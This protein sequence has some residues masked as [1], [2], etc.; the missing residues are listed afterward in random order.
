MERLQLTDDDD[1]D[2]QDLWNSPSKGRSK[3][4][5]KRAGRGKGATL[6][7]P[8]PRNGETVL[9]H[10]E[11]TREAALRHE[12]QTVRNVNQAIEGILE[13]LTRAKGNMETVSRTVDSASTLLNTWTRILSQTEHNQRL[14][15]NPKW[16]GATQD[17]TDM[18]NEAIQK[19]QAA[20]RRELEMQQ[21][22]EAA[23]KKAEEEKKK[24]EAAAAGITR[25]S[26]GT[27]R[28]RVRAGHGRSSS[29]SFSGRGQALGRGTI[30]PRNVSSGITRGS[31]TAR[32]RGKT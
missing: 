22:R 21:R 25:G 24:A 30:A 31:A 15:L 4:P 9:D 20:E 23:A 6:E 19:Q 10:P 2:S 17:I 14:I 13:S 18:E 32:G 7:Q 12:L 8:Y 29:T 26:R 27:N 28:G 1:D 16:Q 5:D 3:T 11:E